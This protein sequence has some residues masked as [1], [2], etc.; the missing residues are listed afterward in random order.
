MRCRVTGACFTEHFKSF[1][2]FIENVF[3]MSRTARYI[4]G[5]SKNMFAMQLP[6]GSLLEFHHVAAV[7]N[8]IWK[9]L[10]PDSLLTWR[11]LPR[12]APTR[13][14]LSCFWLPACFMFCSESGG[15][16]DRSD[17]SLSSISPPGHCTTCL[18]VPGCPSEAACD[19]HSCELMSCF[20]VRPTVNQCGHRR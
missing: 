19:I 13:T 7:C 9:S 12:I 10:S 8:D 4:P 5:S 17:V 16:P 1:H 3:A 6:P 11:H 2:Q 18:G 15:N 20:S 14:I